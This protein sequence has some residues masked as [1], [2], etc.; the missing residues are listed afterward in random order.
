MNI[1]LRCYL[2]RWDVS[3]CFGWLST[4]WWFGFVPKRWIC[5]TEPHQD[6]ASFHPHALQVT[7]L[8]YVFARVPPDVG[9]FSNSSD[10]HRPI[11][12]IITEAGKQPDSHPIQWNPPSSVHITQYILKWR[13]VSVTF[14]SKCLFKNAL[15]FSSFP[16]G[17]LNVLTSEQTVWQTEFRCFLQLWLEFEHGQT[18]WLEGT[19]TPPHSLHTQ[20]QLF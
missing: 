3:G 14:S 1:V 11:Q 10:G 15:F 5:L 20:T 13:V 7:L 4:V 18:K 19:W 16:N 2:T 12:V 17:V 8:Y 9:L 6:V